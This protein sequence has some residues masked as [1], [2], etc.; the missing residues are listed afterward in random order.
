MLLRGAIVALCAAGLAAAAPTKRATGASGYNW[1]KDKIRGL[2]LGGWLVLEPWITPSIFQAYPMSRGIV[3]EY[4]LCDVLGT[5]TAH[6][7]VLK[8]HWDA[9]VQYADMQKIKNSGFNVVR[10]PIGYWAYDNSG[11]PYAS[12]AA[13]YMDKAIGWARQLG[14]KVM[15]DLH[16]APGSQNAF[17]NSGQRLATPGWQS[18][19]NVAKTLRVL[20]TMQTKYGAS[21]YDDVIAGIELL[22]EPLTTALDLNAVKQFEL[23]GYGQQRDVSQSRVVIIQDGFQQP[24]SY[25]GWLSSGG[26]HNVA[27]DHHEYQVFTPELVAMPPWQ[28]RQY[29]CNNANTYAGSDKWTFVGEWSAAMTDCAAALNGYGIGARYEGNYPGSTFVGSCATVNFMET[30][31]QQFKDDTRGY[32]EAQMEAFERYTQGWVFWNFKTEASPEWD[33][34]RLIDAGIFP[35]PLSDRQFSQ[36]CG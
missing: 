26:A 12:G 2:N 13:P 4:T 30:W 25:N 27:L 31:T 28:H 16:G 1:G 36:I 8:P 32:I 23:D 7:T 14:L 33:A 10:I 19:D 3:D 9:W 34:F 20:K 24:S 11:S 29:V 5:N 6:D 21:S 15:V 17:D 18:G 22:N 35:Q